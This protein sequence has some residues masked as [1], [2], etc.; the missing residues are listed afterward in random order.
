MHERQKPIAEWMTATLARHK[1]SARQWSERAGL[2]KDTVSRAMRDNFESITSTRTIAQLADALNE[3]PFGAA[4][5]IPSEASLAAILQVFHAAYAPDR[6]MGPDS[7]QVFAASLRETLLHLAD[8]PDA[9]DD[10][11]MSQTLARSIA[12]RAGTP[13]ATH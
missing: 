11:R 12:R 5:A 6:A 7:L 10:P 1:L 3:R 9:G 4:A 2:G 8:E 13:I